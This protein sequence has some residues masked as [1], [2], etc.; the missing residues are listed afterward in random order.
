M[1]D[2]L[3]RGVKTW[4]AKA[5]FALL[6]ASFAIW[7]IGD[8]FS[9]G[10]SNSVASVGDRKIG[11]ERFAAALNRETQALSQQF[12]QP[13]DPQTVRALGLPQGV[14]GRLVDEAALDAAAAELGV[15]APDEAVRRT[16]LADPSFQTA[17]GGFDEA[18]Y[19]YLLAQNGF[20][21]DGYEAET[22]NA[23]ARAELLRALTDGARAPAGAIEAIYAW[24]TETREIEAAT[25]DAARARDVGAPD[26]AALAAHHEANA[27]E[28]TAPER[29][30]AVFLHLDPVALAAG[31][32]PAEEDLLAAYDARRAEYDRP[33]RRRLF[34]IVYDKRE[35]AEAALARLASGAA[36]FD[37]LLADR[38]ETRGDA[39]LGLVTRAEVSKAVGEA[40][41]G[42][43]ETGVAGP[44]DTGFGFALV[45]VAEIAAAETTPFETARP[46]LETELRRLHGLDLAPERAGEVEER[47]AAGATLEEIA[48]ELG[49]ALGRVEGLGTDGTL[50][51]GAAAEGLAADPAFRDELFAAAEGEEREFVEAS[52]GAF[53]VL[54]VETV[55]PAAL[56]PLAE[57]REA[58]ADSWRAAAV[59]AALTAEAEALAARLS[60]GETL[61][62]VAAELGLATVREGPKTRAEGWA[63]IPAGLA[64]RLFA[65]PAGG[66]AFEPVGETVVLAQVAEVAP[67]R[68][69][70]E[71]L[72]LR[73]GL[74]RQMNGLAAEDALALFAAAKR[75]DLGVSVNQQTLDALLTR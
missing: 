23:L 12:G 11:A 1:L 30:A 5:L 36:D 46:D 38:G 2:L 7:G 39:T 62:A 18:R 33:E 68:P 42:L 22:R 58:V 73:D 69:T 48:A 10:L 14:L 63:A 70:A 6:V 75:A 37:A 44:A 50:T 28:F 53:F 64:E 9:F 4:V 32:A 25:L 67:G 55:A 47:R 35:E 3:R 61:A 52:D 19:R 65:L 51:S 72:A 24:R 20:T 45:E 16:I 54:R 27:A 56:R 43:G 57:V 66:A 40:A 15:S 29:R 59:R 21:P 60:A 49:L 74:E 26:E 41:F 17:A 13:L 34:Q 8:V 31:W 71:N